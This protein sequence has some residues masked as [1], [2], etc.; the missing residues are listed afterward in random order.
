[1]EQE[2]QYLKK[3][4]LDLSRRANEKGIVTF[5]NF[6]NLNEIN[7]FYQ[8][9]KELYSSFQLFGGYE[10]AERQM[11][12]FVPDT[13]CYK[14][15]YPIDAVCITPSSLKFAEQLSHRDVLGALMNLGLKR[16]IL[17]D[18]LFRESDIIVLCVHSISDYIIENC[19][20]I[21]RTMVYCR[22]MENFSFTYEPKLIE[23]ESIVSSLRLDT[24]IADVCKL[25][26]SAAQKIV[27]E[28][29]A[30]VNARKIQQNG[31]NCQNGDILSVRHFGK[32]QIETENALT[33]KGKIKYKYKIYS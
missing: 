31:Y 32:F 33:K 23:K 28:G 8:L 7:I 14:W 19:I 1:M 30:F 13:L 22:Q 4:L 26:R 29:N 15:E 20:Q 5:S 24:I 18:I 10:Q 21:R 6:L 25:S 27:F 12:A 3:H 16:E 11:A 9:T 17:G 2:L